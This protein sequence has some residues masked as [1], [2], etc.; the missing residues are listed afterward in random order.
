M[1][2]K[3]PDKGDLSKQEYEEAWYFNLFLE[4]CPLHVVEFE[5]GRKKK[6]PDIIAMLSDGSKLA[7]EL[8]EILDRADEQFRSNA[9]YLTGL[10]NEEVKRLTRFNDYRGYAVSVRF[11]ED[12]KYKQRPDYIK[13]VVDLLEANHH[14]PRIKITD[15]GKTIGSIR[16]TNFKLDASPYFHVSNANHVG[17]YTLERI[18]DKCFEKDYETP[19]DIHLLAYARRVWDSHHDD[20]KELF[21]R[22][23][24]FKRLW[25]F[26]TTDKKTTLSLEKI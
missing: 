15:K 18:Y 7:F 14:T 22:Q 8:T 6:E 10:L 3:Y 11:T 2:A 21:D 24:T 19:H 1:A 9:F 20:V 23:N 17:D 16:N 5:P 26:D 13:L 4:Q 12:V 25:L